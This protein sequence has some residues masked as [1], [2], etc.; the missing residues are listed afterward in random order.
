MVFVGG[1]EDH[2]LETVRSAEDY[3]E[4]YENQTW[5]LGW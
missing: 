3:F 5:K 1:F 4:R 2:L